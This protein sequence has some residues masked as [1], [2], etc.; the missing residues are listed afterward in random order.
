[1]VFV[2]NYSHLGSTLV[3]DDI[4]NLSDGPL[5]VLKEILHFD[6]PSFDAFLQHQGIFHLG[7]EIILGEAWEGD[8]GAYLRVAELVRKGS[9]PSNAEDLQVF[10]L[11][12]S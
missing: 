4:L 10:W 6:T 5:P 3:L 7:Q 8:P 9:S 12:L 2:S 11:H 1:V